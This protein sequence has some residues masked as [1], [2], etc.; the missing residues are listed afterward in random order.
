MAK[1]PTVIVNVA[2]TVDGKLDTVA[3]RGAAISS[4]ADFSRVD[5]LRAESDAIMV[6]AG[7]IRQNDPRLT[8]KSPALRAA[9]VQ[10]RQ[11][12]N[13][14]KVGVMSEAILAPDSRFISH[15]PARIILCTSR[16][17]MPHV[18]ELWR[19]HGVEV[20][21]LG[22]QRVDLAAAMHYLYKQGHRQVLVEGGGT[23]IAGLL[24]QR[25][26]DELRVYVAPKIFGGARAPTLADGPGWPVNKTVR[27]TLL[28]A[29][30]VEDSGMLLRYGVSE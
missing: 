17:T 21:I 18:V 12:P 28:A 16:R 14:T 2:M 3:R 24:A 23:L 13:P 8:V 6:G 29:D 9:R 10:R 30:V 20:V 26:V 1:R 25:L 22:K 7:T 15:G 27:L 4:A 11:P 19:T 5:R